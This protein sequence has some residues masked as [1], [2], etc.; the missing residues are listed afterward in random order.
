[1]KIDRLD[2][3]NIHTDRLDET[4]RFYEDVMGLTKGLAP[5]LD[6]EMT[7]WMFDGDR[8]LIHLGMAGSILGE[9]KKDSPA[10]APPAPPPGSGAVHHV[11][12]NC[13]DYDAM[14]DRL[15]RLGVPKQT[16]YVE[17][18]DLKQIFIHDPNGVMLELNFFGDASA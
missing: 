7:A 2:H 16:N 12:F 3:V 8:A 15:E 4:V 18:V 6:L 5:G 17:A 11:A 9:A 10:G 1:M 13:R 14:I